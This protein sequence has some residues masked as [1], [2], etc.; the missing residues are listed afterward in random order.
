M[1][2]KLHEDIVVQHK[3]KGVSVV[4]EKYVHLGSIVC[5]QGTF[6]QGSHQVGSKKISIAII[7]NFRYILN[8]LLVICWSK[9][10]RL[11]LPIIRRWLT[12]VHIVNRVLTCQENVVEI[13][14]DFF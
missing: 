1:Q 2:R 13:G 12:N 6:L 3:L 10:A 14:L 7:L 9:I 8:C 5:Y 11:G 4:S